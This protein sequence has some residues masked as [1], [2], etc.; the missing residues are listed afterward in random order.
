MLALSL[1][2]ATCGND[3]KDVP[4][5]VLRDYQRIFTAC[6]QAIDSAQPVKDD[7][8][9]LTDTY[10][11]AISNSVYRNRPTAETTLFKIDE[12]RQVFL[13]GTDP[14][15]YLVAVTLES[16]SVFQRRHDTNEF[17][18]GRRISPTFTASLVGS[19]VSDRATYLG[20]SDSMQI[21]PPDPEAPSPSPVGERYSCQVDEGLL[22]YR[23][24]G[25]S[26]SHESE[27]RIDATLGRR[28]LPTID[29][30][31]AE[32]CEG[33]CTKVSGPHFATLNELASEFGVLIDVQSRL[34]PNKLLYMAVF[35]DE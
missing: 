16:A 26:N 22:I 19:F 8:K 27:Q 29:F 11:D 31:R 23:N 24:I 20:G 28:S 21:P 3:D 10:F 5:D 13:T 32:V 33:G 18:F 15:Y 7:I 35:I 12:E 2:S 14:Q 9:Q 4:S 1:L 6:K 17:E 30:R 34:I 25:A